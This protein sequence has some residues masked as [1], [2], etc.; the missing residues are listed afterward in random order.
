MALIRTQ[1]IVLRTRDLGE[2]DRLVTLFTRDLGRV[3]GVARGARRLRSRFGAALELFT[4]GDAVGFEREGRELIRLDHFDIR[5]SFRRLREDLDRLGHGAR[6][7]EA[8][9]MLT[10]E[11]DSHPAC[12]SLLLRGLRVLEVSP[13]ARVQL[14]FTLR[15]LDLLGHRPRFD[16]C[17][18]CRRPVG[19]MAVA[20]EPSRGGVL[21]AACRPASGARPGTGVLSPLVVAVLRGLQ[22]ATWETALRAR[23]AAP[24]EREAA[25]VLDGYVVVLSGGPL[26]TPRFLAQTAGLSQ[27]P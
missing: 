9:M 10:G 21:C 26:K 20:F 5:R 3:T 13:P 19:T 14:A 12:F 23:I 25:Q 24:V 16:G 2:Y 6:M 17:V 22:R 27:D 4:W 11:R 15:A 8:I 1:G 7:V 18:G